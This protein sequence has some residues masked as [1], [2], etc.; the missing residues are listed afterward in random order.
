MC[1]P[2]EPDGVWP[3]S[4]PSGGGLSL[5]R[6]AAAALPP[7]V[8]HAGLDGGCQPLTSSNERCSS[9]AASATAPHRGPAVQIAFTHCH[10]LRSAQTGWLAVRR[11][12]LAAAPCVVW[13][14]QL[15]TP[16]C[17]LSPIG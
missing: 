11:G 3:V 7:F 9:N 15:A 4:M 14:G 12:G 6:S 2:E 17:A 16:H 1:S 5:C 8:S 13:G 10:A